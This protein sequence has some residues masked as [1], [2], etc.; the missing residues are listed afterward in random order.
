MR[1][2]QKDQ[3]TE[4]VTSCPS[5]FSAQAQI[6]FSHPVQYINSAQIRFYTNALPSVLQ[7]SPLPPAAHLLQIEAQ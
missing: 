3:N 6:L 4:S 1:D 7:A 2:V 5:M